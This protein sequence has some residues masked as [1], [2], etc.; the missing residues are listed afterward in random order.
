MPLYMCSGEHLSVVVSVLLFLFYCSGCSPFIFLQSF[1]LPYRV[2]SQ[3]RGKLKHCF[4]CLHPKY[5]HLQRTESPWIRGRGGN[6]TAWFTGTRQLHIQSPQ[7]PIQW[8]EPP[9]S[10]IGNLP[11]EGSLLQ[12]IELTIFRWKAVRCRVRSWD[13]TCRMQSAARNRGDNFPVQCSLLQDTEWTPY[14][15][16]AVC[17]RIRNEHLSNA[18]QSSSLY[19]FWDLTSRMQS[20]HKVRDEH[21]TGRM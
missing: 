19:E 18:M 7:T 15:C 8:R 2:I 1:S 16:N 11:M 10:G 6:Y 12:G 21:I 14:R 4:L 5:F 9:E 17:R 3:C 13:L 20:A